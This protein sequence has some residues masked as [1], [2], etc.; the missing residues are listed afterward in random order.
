MW[1]NEATGRNFIR[2]QLKGRSPNTEAAGARIYLTIGTV[3][4][5]REIVIGSNFVSQNPTIQVMGLD[6][7]TQVDEI[8][9]QWPDGAE[10]VERNVAAGRTLLISQAGA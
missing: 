7:A 9:V 6:T 5:M 4:Q 2:I 3:T 1:R 8:R 10:S